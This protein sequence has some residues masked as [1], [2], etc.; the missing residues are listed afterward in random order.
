MTVIFVDTSVLQSEVTPP[1]RQA[2]VSRD[3]LHEGG[4]A[5]APGTD[6][7]TT[8][9]HGGGHFLLPRLLFG[10]SSL[11]VAVNYGGVAGGGMTH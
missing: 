4:H 10:P 2:A 3:F 8:S 5:G 9:A 1:G 6:S 7:K 11:D